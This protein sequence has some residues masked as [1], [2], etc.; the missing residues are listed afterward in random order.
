MKKYILFLI[1]LTA[2]FSCDTDK[3][4][5]DFSLGIKPELMEYTAMIEIFDIADTAIIPSN[6]L[7]SVESDNAD[8]IY[9][10]SGISTLDVIDGKIQI[11][12]HPRAN[13]ESGEDAVVVSLLVTADGYLNRRETIIFSVGEEQQLLSIAMVNTTSP[14]QGVSFKTET[15]NLVNDELPA[16]F[17]LEVTPGQ[18]SNVGMTIDLPQGTQFLDAANNLISGSDLD[19]QIGQ[20]DPSSETALQAFPGGFS[21][22]S[23]VLADGTAESGS[24]VT[25]G[26]TTMNMSVNG[27]AVKNFSNPITVT[28]DLAAGA[29]NPST[30]SPVALGDSVPV[31]SY[32]ETDGIWEYETTGIAIQGPNSLQVSYQTTHL[33][34]WNLDF[35]GT[36]CCGWT[37]TRVGRRWTRSYNPCAEMTINMP[38][39]GN[40]REWFLF[41][42]VIAGTNQPVSRYA[43]RSRRVYDGAK[44]RYYNTPSFPVQVKAYD[45]RNGALVGQTAPISLCSGSPTMTLNANPPFSVSLDIT[46]VCED[47]PNVLIRP[48]FYVYF[49]KPNES[50]Y[51]YLTYVYSGTASTTRLELGQTY[52]FRTYIGGQI[53][54]KTETVT[55]A[56]YSY[57]V[58][59][60]NYC[61]N[62]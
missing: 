55:Q 11:G 1:V 59:L 48:Y 49:K 45:R 40:T 54:D 35:Y 32:D 5:N 36:R 62:F 25:A 29:L 18:G 50:Y 30:G 4:I 41:K 24:F 60:G 10:G 2:S 27:T 15:T 26:Y 56:N 46:G 3:V 34:F 57:Q 16:N 43:S 58:E 7:L 33:S 19:M 8:N 31:W 21:P 42:V 12:L 6:I 47:S 38:G 14:P 22:D 44:I 9:E 28:M 39:W 17:N 52:N 20:F 13:P 37:W 61:N 51:R 23:I 53:I